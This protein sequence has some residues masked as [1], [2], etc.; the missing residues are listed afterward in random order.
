MSGPSASAWQSRSKDVT[1]ASDKQS[2]LRP[3]PAV[4]SYITSNSFEIYFRPGLYGS[5]CIRSLLERHVEQA[6]SKRDK[7]SGGRAVVL[8]G[9]GSGESAE[10][11]GT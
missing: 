11:W 10:W 4:R 7:R 2:D 8:H 1:L 3:L 6:W 5:S 9:Q